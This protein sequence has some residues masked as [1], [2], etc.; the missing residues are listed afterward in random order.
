MNVKEQAIWAMG[1]IAGDSANNRDLVIN[2]GGLQALLEDRENVCIIYQL[3][4]LIFNRSCYNRRYFS[5][6]QYH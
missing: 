2:Q 3:V 1:N 5:M 6:L 4:G